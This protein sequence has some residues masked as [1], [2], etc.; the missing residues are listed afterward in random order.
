[1][2]NATGRVLDAFWRAAVYCLHPRVMLL[3][4]APLLI[5]GL[6]A[7]V[8]GYFFWEDAV[9]AV[10]ISLE[11]WRLVD[12]VLGWLAHVG[13]GSLR[14]MIAPLIVLA[15]AIPVVLLLSLLL[16]ALMMTPAMV[17]LV[18]LRRFPALELK[19]GGSLLMSVAWSIG[20][21]LLAL[22]LIVLSMPL[23]L[24]PPLILFIP[25][26]IWGWLGYRVFAFDVLSDH[27]SPQE[28]RQL[29]S[30]H[31][32]QLLAIGM[33]TGYLGAAPASILFIFIPAAPL[34]AV[35]AVWLYTLVFAF[36]SLWFAHYALAALNDL[37]LSRVASSTLIDGVEVLE[38]LAG[39]SGDPEGRAVQT[40][41]PV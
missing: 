20:H 25:P 14:T 7:G 22:A 5:C 33:L 6:A 35:P 28:R 16:V 38:P 12:T 30:E 2:L 36:T 29:L 37:R 41:P 15:I 9:D 31:K 18:A 21:T 17:R 3:S 34:L 39:S 23:W 1:M 24:V 27:A 11:S 32:F 10:R 13:L 8:S 19:H 26:L 40:L 4:L